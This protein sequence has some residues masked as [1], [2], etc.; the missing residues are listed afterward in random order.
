MHNLKFEFIPIFPGAV[1]VNLKLIKFQT[2]EH[3]LEKFLLYSCMD[4]SG[5]EEQSL[6]DSSPVTDA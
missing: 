5:G 4:V 3:I 6:T 1:W 2:N